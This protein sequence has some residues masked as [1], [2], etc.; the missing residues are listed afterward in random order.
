M[1]PPPPRIG[2]EIFAPPHPPAINNERS[3]T[4][5]IV[6]AHGSSDKASQT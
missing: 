5:P 3:L 2:R 6:S 4:T 1:P